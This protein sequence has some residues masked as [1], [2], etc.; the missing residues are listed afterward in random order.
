MGAMSRGKMD[1]NEELDLWKDIEQL[2]DTIYDSLDLI[3]I[4]THQTSFEP[5]VF[6][7]MEYLE[8]NVELLRAF[9]ENNKNWCK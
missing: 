1:A 6:L 8:R 9:Y 5:D 3:E 4:S 2:M 7:E